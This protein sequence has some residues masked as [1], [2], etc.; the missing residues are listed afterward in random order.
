MISLLA[1]VDWKRE[2]WQQQDEEE[3]QGVELNIE[4]IT[5]SIHMHIFF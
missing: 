4:S 3:T 2:T 1:L 5:L